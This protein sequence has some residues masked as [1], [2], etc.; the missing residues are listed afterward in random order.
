MAVHA[1]KTVESRD[2]VCDFR[3][4]PAPGSV[5]APAGKSGL[6]K[7]LDQALD[8]LM[9]LGAV[10]QA[11]Q[12]TSATQTANPEQA[13]KEI[14]PT[15]GIPRA[16]PAGID[17]RRSIRPSVKEETAIPIQRKS[18]SVPA[19]TA[20]ADALA[21]ALEAAG[22]R[23]AQPG[24]VDIADLLSEI[25]GAAATSPAVSSAF[26]TSALLDVQDLAGRLKKALEG[27]KAISKSL[28]LLRPESSNSI[29]DL[30]ELAVDAPPDSHDKSGS[31]VGELLGRTL[32]ENQSRPA[33]AERGSDELLG[34]HTQSTEVFQT[35]ARRVSD[36]GLTSSKVEFSHQLREVADYLATRVQGSMHVANGE[37]QAELR[38]SPP[39]LGGVKV[40]L[41]MTAD[42][43][44]QTHFVVENRETGALLTQNVRQFTDA[45]GRHGLNVDKVQV[46]VDIKETS[47]S[48]TRNETGENR[49]GGAFSSSTPRGER[50]ESRSA[51]KQALDAWQEAVLERNA[52]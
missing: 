8:F 12:Q 52:A 45:L 1:V 2:S 26:K 9:E 30:S 25:K 32:G 42:R 19:H 4:T 6:S 48:D 10:F 20:P 14:P 37:V 43:T 23:S 38:L 16:T 51:R 36:A 47:R 18:P 21:K 29:P 44:V 35:A 3:R 13:T 31:A 22:L 7:S 11:L 5:A 50:E 27:S 17:L 40:E 24:S 46:T 15:N 28:E 33:S 39:D 41:T 49:H 34:I